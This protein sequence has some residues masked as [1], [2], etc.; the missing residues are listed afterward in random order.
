[1]AVVQ[2]PTMIVEDATTKEGSHAVRRWICSCRSPRKTCRLTAAWPRRRVRSGREHGA[3]EYR[4]CAGDDLK[5]KFGVP[6]SRSAK[7]KP[8]ETV[9]FSW[10]VFKSRAHRDRVNAKVMK[11]PRIAD[12]CDPKSMPFELQAHGLRRIQGPGRRLAPGLLRHRAQY[13]YVERS[14]WVE[15]WRCKNESLT[16][17]ELIVILQGGNHAS[18]APDSSPVS[19]LSCLASLAVAKEKK[20]EKPRWTRRP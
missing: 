8:G 11:D 17:I 9:V 14:D 6:L 13:M 3:L 10:I 12:M 5:V 18:H 15:K 4:E 7:A 2:S 1:M 19:V 20:P 16:I